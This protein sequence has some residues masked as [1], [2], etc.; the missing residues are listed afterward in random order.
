MAF[1][2]P[3][4][5]IRVAQIPEQD[6]WRG[7]VRRCRQQLC[8]VVWIPGDRAHRPA[9]VVQ[10]QRRLLGLEIP[11][12][13]ESSRA[14]GGQDMR[15]FDVPRNTLQIVRSSSSSAKTKGTLGIIHVVYEKLALCTGC[16]KNLWPEGVELQ[17]F[18]GTGVLSR[19]GNQ[20]V[21]IAVQ[22]FFGVPQVERAILEGTS[23]DTLGVVVGGLTPSNIVESAEVCWCSVRER[24]CS[25]RGKRSG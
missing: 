22:K 5:S 23:D 14:T 13:D 17:G 25:R 10:G 24:Q 1:Q 12:S 20:S 6:N 4:R 15:N 8:R 16:G 9:V 18:D 2:N 19:S 21:V 11:D 7:V 3:F